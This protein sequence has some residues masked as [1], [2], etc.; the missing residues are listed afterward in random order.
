MPKQSVDLLILESDQTI[1]VPSNIEGSDVLGIIDN[2]GV[3]V[4]K[5]QVVQAAASEFLERKYTSRKRI[6]ANE[7]IILPGFVDPHTHL[8]FAGSREDEFE[9]RVAGKGYMQSLRGGGGIIE[10]VRR[11]RY[12]LPDELYS[13]G[14]KRLTHALS[15]GT[16]TVEVKTGY[17]LDMSGEAKMLRVINRLRKFHQSNV[18][19]TFL[20]AHAVPPESPTTDDYTRF[21]LGDLLPMARKIG[22]AVFLDVFCETGVVSTPQGRLVFMGGVE[23]G[24]KAEISSD[25]VPGHWG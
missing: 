17:G 24:F 21:L 12:A 14:Y 7:Q 9:S 11:T 3:A 18:I 10:T 25:E 13:T 22:G 15:N 5:G 20:G 4:D 1:T 6:H 23:V 19:G 2:G 8:V 16:T